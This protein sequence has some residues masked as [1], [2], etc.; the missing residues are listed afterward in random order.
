MSL[1][2]KINGHTI[3]ISDR[4]SQTVNGNAVRDEEPHDGDLSPFAAA[5]G[6]KCFTEWAPLH[7]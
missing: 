3:K 5:V 2:Y 6:Q 7:M 4:T 1:V